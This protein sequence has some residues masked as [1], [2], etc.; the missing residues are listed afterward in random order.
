MSILATIKR[1][2]TPIL[3]IDLPG[4]AIQ[5]CTV[6]VALAQSDRMVVKTN[7][8]NNDCISMEPIMSGNKQTGTELLVQFSQHD[9][10][11][12]LPGKAKVEVRW[13]NEEGIADKSDI[14]TIQIPTTLYQGVI[15]YGRE[16]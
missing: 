9:T 6:Y 5:D 13:I 10:L 8:N 3:T 2:T 4:Q 7:Y 16:K 14:G 15:A 11:A 12:L 1:G